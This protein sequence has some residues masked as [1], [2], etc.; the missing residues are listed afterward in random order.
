M[1]EALILLNRLA[2]SPIYSKTTLDVL[3]R[4][5]TCAS[6]T[7]DI[8]NRIPRIGRCGSHINSTHMELEIADL[9]RVF[10]SRLFSFVA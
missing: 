6:L 1:R 9:A 7:I 3:T 8:A 2:S 10:Q 5:K 4:S